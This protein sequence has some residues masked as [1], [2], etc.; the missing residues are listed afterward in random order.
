MSAGVAAGLVLAAVCALGTNIGWMIK[1]RGAQQSPRMRHRHPLQSVRILLR[2]R[3]FLAGLVIAT[4]AGALH[5]GALALA[6]ISIVQA[7]MAG[8]LVILVVLAEPV[9]G[10]QVSRRQWSGVI[11]SAVGLALL[12]ITLPAIGGAHNHF[13]TTT[14]TIFNALALAGSLLLLIAPRSRR[15]AAHDGALLGAAAGVLFGIADV[16]VKALLGT[17]HAGILEALLSVWLPVAVGAGILAQYVSARSLQTGDAVSVTALT[18][19]AVTIIN[20]VGGIIVFGDPVAHGP[21]GTLAEAM[22]FALICVAAFLTPMPT[23]TTRTP[24]A[25]ATA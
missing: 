10:W 1:H 17:A 9:F 2:S 5:I 21:A 18:G 16:A 19:V 13:S 12:G 7:V 3:W 14:M 15:L 20:I 22:A 24:S 4:A 6:P 11:L 25:A 23:G 8:G